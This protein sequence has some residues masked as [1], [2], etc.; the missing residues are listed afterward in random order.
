VSHVAGA[1]DEAH[2]RG[3]VHRDVKP[4][5]ILIAVREGVE[6]AYLT[7]FGLTKERAVGAELTGTGLAIGT[8][9]YIAP[10]QAQGTALDG[11][12]DVYALGCVLFQALAGT[13]PFARDSDLEKMWAHVHDP[14]PDL[15]ERRPELPRGLGDIVARAMAKDPD[16]RQPTAGELAREAAAA[17][18]D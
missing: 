14:P 12:A 6:K 7:D 11:R 4:A 9:D 13:V 3:L 5:N 17:L 1:L 18:M 10:E 15:L 16:D 2:G 8:A